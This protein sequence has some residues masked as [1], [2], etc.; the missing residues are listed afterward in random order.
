MEEKGIEWVCPNCAKKKDEEIKTKLNTQNASG[1]QRIQSDN[2]FDNPK[3]LT[4]VNQTSFNEEI[5]PLIRS[6]CDYGSVQYSS[7]MQCVVCKKEARNS[8]IYCSDACILAHAQET[9]TKD[10]PIPG[11]TTSPKGTRLSPFDS[12]S[13]PKSDTR[14]I[15]FE[16][17]SGTVLTGKLILFI[18][19]FQLNLYLKKIYFYLLLLIFFKVRMLQQDQ[20]YVYG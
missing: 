13:K 14:V 20:I 2:I 10:K 3:S 4:S 19:R 1:K 9:L 8:S 11:S 6:N 18:F 5:S 15:V 16:R 17:K 12:A 7:G